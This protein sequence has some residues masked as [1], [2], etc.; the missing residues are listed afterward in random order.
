MTEKHPKAWSWWDF[1]LV[2][3]I[4]IDNAIKDCQELLL[5]S[6]VDVTLI[7]MDGNIYTIDLN[8]VNM[9]KIAE[10]SMRTGSVWTR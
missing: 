2:H 6:S 10:E 8:T 9:E 7:K 5:T 3:L 1:Q 4:K